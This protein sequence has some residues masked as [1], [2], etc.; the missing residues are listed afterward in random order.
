MNPSIQL[1]FD[2]CGVETHC[3]ASLHSIMVNNHLN[4]TDCLITVSKLKVHSS[5]GV[6]LS[7]KNMVGLLPIQKYGIN[8]TGARTQYVHY[9]DQRTQIPYNICGYC[10]C[11][12]G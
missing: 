10:K 11:I 12:S 6:T 1:L 5:A 4:E 3:N 8:G 7:L 9:P 2:G